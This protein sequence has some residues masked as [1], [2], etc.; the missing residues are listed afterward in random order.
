MM[1]SVL[2]TALM[3]SSGVLK[4]ENG[5]VYPVKNFGG[6]EV[7]SQTWA[8]ADSFPALQ[9]SVERPN[10]LIW[11]MKRVDRPVDGLLFQPVDELQ[12]AAEILTLS[13]QRFIPQKG[14]PFQSEKGVIMDWQWQVV[15]AVVNSYSEL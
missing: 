7:T 2:V 14:K 6:W 4:Y 12:I 8:C 10:R 5:R 1:V 13:F 3:I 9:L 11:G 15:L